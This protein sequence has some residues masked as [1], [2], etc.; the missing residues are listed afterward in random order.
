MAVPLTPKPTRKA[1]AL[2]KTPPTIVS[3]RKEDV[4]LKE[5]VK[6]A[7]DGA[8]HPRKAFFFGTQHRVVYLNESVIPKRVMGESVA[9]KF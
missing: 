1:E 2:A 8:N 4:A 6:K 5:V 9:W 3:R 7:K